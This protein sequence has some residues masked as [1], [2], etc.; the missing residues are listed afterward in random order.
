MREECANVQAAAADQLN[1]LDRNLFAVYGQ[2]DQSPVL[3]WLPIVLGFL[4]SAI[5]STGLLSRPSIPNG[6]S[7]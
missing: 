7:W 6:V 1:E 4:A 5:V 2:P 3:T